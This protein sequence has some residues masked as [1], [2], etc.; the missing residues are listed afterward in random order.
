MGP[1]GYLFIL[2]I[3][4]IPIFFLRWR[5]T[6]RVKDWTKWMFG[7]YVT[8]LV[9]SVVLYAFMMNSNV[10][11]TTIV[12]EA[13]ASEEEQKFHEAIYQGRTDEVDPKEVEKTF[14]IAYHNNQLHIASDSNDDV[15]AAVIVEKKRV[16]DHKIEGIIYKPKLFINELDVSK[17]IKP[18]EIKWSD[19]TLTIISPE[20]TELRF[21]MLKRE[22]P[23][24]QFT[25]EQ[26]FDTHTT[27]FERPSILYL[28]VPKEL[29]ING[30]STITIHFLEE[31]QTLRN[32][33][34]L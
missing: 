34:T 3:M 23:F 28:R 25:G 4:M 24:T 20:V 18:L 9:L 22:F 21:A 32:P 14:E 26:W 27:S 30:Q 2:V 16:D 12:S 29:K 33:S 15:D 11:S 1:I 5:K 7:G 31:T 6:N 13:E 8:I 10:Q 19:D 17:E